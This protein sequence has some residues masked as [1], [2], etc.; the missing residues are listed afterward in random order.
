MLLYA[1]DRF[2]EHQTGHHPE[3][4]A[5]LVA[6]NS[7][8][9]SSGL[10][11][12]CT[13]PSWQPAT[14]QQQHLVHRESYTTQI[15]LMAKNGGGQIEQD[16]VVSEQSW[17]VTRLAAGA[18][19]D[20]VQRV[21]AGESKIAFC[22]IRPPGH[23]ALAGAAMGFCL[24]NNVAVAARYATTTLALDRVLVIDWDVHHGNG[25]QAIFYDD[26]TVGF[27]SIH[28]WPFYPGTGDESETGTGR[29]LGSTLNHPVEYGTTNANFIE[30]FRV[31]V[32][33][34]AAKIKPQLILLSAGFDA[35]RLDPVGSL[36]LESEDFST[37][38]GIVQA[39]ADEY[40]DGKLVSI[41]EGGYNPNALADSVV[42]HVQS[43]LSSSP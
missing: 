26:P 8:L 3:N 5:R 37:L 22:A 15:E 12:R 38:T 27:Y 14:A 23:H 41:L 21:I 35:H 20:A 19:C 24:L 30:R 11:D 4:A 13:R 10:L 28:R 36:G 7:A 32:E 17:D 29:G 25:T 1:D 16:T 9:A 33:L 40:C 31:G 18:V 43:L 2:L 6:V 34:L 39:T 42:N